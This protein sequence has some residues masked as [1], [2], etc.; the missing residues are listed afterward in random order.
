MT[1]WSQLKHAY[2]SA[3]AIPG[4]LDEAAADP[5][6]PVWSDLSSCLFHQG[7]VYSASYAALPMLTQIASHWSP[8][9]RGM[10]LFLAGGIIASTDRPEEHADPHVTYADECARL[11]VLTEESLGEPMLADDPIAYIYLLQTLLGLEG[12]AVWSE[13]LEGIN[14]EEYQ[15]ACPQCEADNFIVFGHHGY[16]SSLNSS[17]RSNATNHRSTPLLPTEP[18]T[19][20]GLAQRL[21]AR[22]LANG[23]PEIADKL[24]YVFGSACCAQCATKFRVDHAIV[25]QYS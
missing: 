23:H 20:E 16:Y 17:F 4:M 3:E 2:G 5:Y 21:H 9:D 6:S 10:P 18:P 19:L 24:T 12:V 11:T 7:T 13:H 22:A 1:D 14:N 15:V 8:A 25:A